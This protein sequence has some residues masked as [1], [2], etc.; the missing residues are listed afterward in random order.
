ML[1]KL[2]LSNDLQE[3]KEEQERMKINNCN[4]EEDRKEDNA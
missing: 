4:G 2:L 3:L 1:T